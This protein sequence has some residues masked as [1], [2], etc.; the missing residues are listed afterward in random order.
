MLAAVVVVLGPVLS[1]VPIGPLQLAVGALTLLFGLRWLRKAIL[2]S[3]G[4]IKLHD[5]TAAYAAEVARLSA[6]GRSPGRDLVAFSTAFQI[7]L[8]EGMEVVF[9]V[10]AIGAGGAGL[11]VPAGL[12]A[13][14][15]LLLVIVLG[16]VVH[17]PLAQVPENTLK[18][19]VGVL[20]SGFG[21]FWVGEGIGLSWP[22]A[23]WAILGLSLGFLL[24]ALG[25]VQVG[26]AQLAR[27]PA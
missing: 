27:V 16:L 26:R 8:L 10:L 20:L 25:L 11:L 12:G 15:A 1:R 22:G 13:L 2:R 6:L 7:T 3:V 24:V 9:I 23:D 4:V 19:M 5:E 17:R 14:A 21:T 18:F